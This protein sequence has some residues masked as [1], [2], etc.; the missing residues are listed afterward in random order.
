M[1]PCSIP[2]EDVGLVFLYEK[3]AYLGLLNSSNPLIHKLG[4]RMSVYFK[5]FEA[6]LGDYRSCHSRDVAKIQLLPS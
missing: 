5:D 2:S 6:L 3:M 4:G 1:I